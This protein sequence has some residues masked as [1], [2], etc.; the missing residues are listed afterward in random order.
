M[1]LLNNSRLYYRYEKM[2]VLSGALED[3]VRFSAFRDLVD[4]VKLFRGRGDQ[5]QHAG[6][7]KVCCEV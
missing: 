4:T 7:F 5:A 3:E 6:E 1:N 2:E